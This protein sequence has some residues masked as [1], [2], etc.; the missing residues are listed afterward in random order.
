MPG[1]VQAQLAADEELYRRLA[2]ALRAAPPLAVTTLARG[3]SEHA[4]RYL[5]FLAG[6]RRGILVSRIP[7]SLVTLYRA[8]LRAERLLAIAVSQSGQSPDLLEPVRALRAAGGTAVAL[9]NDPASPLAAEADWVLPLRAGPEVAVPATK[10]FVA[11]LVAGARL[12]GHWCE[13][14]PLLAAL[15]ALPAALEDGLR[16][17]W[18]AAAGALAGEER[19]YVVA[20]GLGFP[21]AQE[22]AL[23]LKEA[24]GIQAEAFSAAE[25]RHGPMGLV[26]PGY[27]VLVLALRGPAQ[28]DLVAFAEE[29]RRQGAKVILAAPGGVPGRDLTLATSAAEELDPAAAVASVYPMVDALARARG[30]DPDRPPN[31]VK[32]M[33][34]R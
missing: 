10:S 16:Q 9:V 28:A 30:R 15:G 29:L 12:V 25:V 5:G 1:L 18:S 8:P 21:L 27:P 13:D 19:M 17:D 4:A 7:P 34:T 11:S 26:G 6:A 20:R 3:S 33:S 14:E 31:L 22:T 2:A 32:V 24:C 23:K